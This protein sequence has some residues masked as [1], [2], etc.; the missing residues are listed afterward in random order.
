LNF[1]LSF[2]NLFSWQGN[3]KFEKD[4]I[5]YISL[6]K[7]DSIKN[8]YSFERIINP[9]VENEDGAIVPEEN[10]SPFAIEQIAKNDS[11]FWEYSLV[12]PQGAILINSEPIDTA[13]ISQSQAPGFL[14]WK[15]PAG[16]AISKRILL[17]ADFSL[18]EQKSISSQSLI[19]IALGCIV[20][21]LAIAIL[22]RK[23]KNLG[24]TLKELKNT[25][26]NLKGE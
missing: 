20:M 10:I 2:E 19:G 18:P 8:G 17:R 26:K 7:I 13:Y 16:E 14:R 9:T 15:F 22:F 1:K 21:L 23:L 6:K 3:K 11:V 24:T 5:G 25:E 4:L 12:L